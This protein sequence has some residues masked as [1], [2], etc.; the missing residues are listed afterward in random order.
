MESYQEKAET[1]SKRFGISGVE[2]MK[3]L[4]ECD[5]DILD[6]VTRLEN[7]GVIS[8]TSANYSTDLNGR[9]LIPHRHIPESSSSAQQPEQGST[10]SRLMDIAVNNSFE[11]LRNDRLIAAIPVLVLVILLIFCFWVVI[12]LT[13]A[14][15]FLGCRY[16]FS[17][18]ELNREDINSTMDKAAEGAEKI[19][20]EIKN[21]INNRSSGKKQG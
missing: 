20:N 5:G 15:L 9:P 1:L 3:A 18:K 2:A 19:K 4:E 11:I 8:R 14:G 12:P 16:R 7:R 21:E 17:G 10:F 13:V 6:A